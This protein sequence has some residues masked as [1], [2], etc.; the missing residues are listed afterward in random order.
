MI[1]TLT[2]YFNSFICFNYFEGAGES[3]VLFARCENKII[4]WF[5]MYVYI[6]DILIRHTY[7]QV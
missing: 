7:R 3:L 6:G 5:G 1:D 2:L 4:Y